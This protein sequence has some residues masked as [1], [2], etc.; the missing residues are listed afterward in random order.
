MIPMENKKILLV[1]VIFFAL[2]IKC[3]SKNK[4]FTYYRVLLHSVRKYLFCQ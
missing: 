2:F 1:W 4:F 3:L